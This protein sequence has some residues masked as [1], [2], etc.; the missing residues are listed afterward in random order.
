MDNEVVTLAANGLQPERG[1]SSEES[2]SVVWAPVFGLIAADI[3]CLRQE[4]VRP[5]RLLRLRG[6]MI[7][8]LGSI[9]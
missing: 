7:L 6:R 3:A 4:V 2:V 9:I 5:I 8:L 1:S